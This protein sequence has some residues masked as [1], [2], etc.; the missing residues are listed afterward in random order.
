MPAARYQKRE[1]A[2]KLAVFLKAFSMGKSVTAAAAEAGLDRRSLYRLR[3]RDA[4]FAERWQLAANRGADLGRCKDDMDP[5]EHE[6]MRRA[7]EGVSKP[8]FRGGICVGHT[9][10][11]SDAMLMFLLKAKYP[12]KYNRRDRAGDAP[13][14]MDIDG[15]LDALRSKFD[16]SS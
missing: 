7:V 16:P 6:A 13:V 2:A 14:D 8:V 10:D 3:T 15:A 9:R 1:R 5:L 11:Y 12:E 4:L